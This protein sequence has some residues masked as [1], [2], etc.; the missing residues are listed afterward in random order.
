[1]KALFC[2]D[3]PIQRNEVGQHYSPVINNIVFNRYLG[4]A[5][6]LKVAI[7]VSDFNNP[8]DARKS[9]LIDE[10]NVEII[11]IP[12]LSSANGIIFSKAK[13]THILA[14]Q[15]RSVDFSIIRLPSFIGQAAVNIARKLHKP[16]LVEI[17]G[18]PWDSLWNYGLKGKFVAPWLTLSMKR[19]VKDA[20]YAIYV[21]NSFLQSRYPTNGVSINCSDVEINA[22]DDWV[23]QSRIDK[24]RKN[25]AK[26]ILG[27][28]AAVNVPY[29]GQQYVI[30]ALGRMK[31][32][33]DTKYVY[34]MVGDGD[35]SRLEQVIRENDVM[36]Q[37]EFLGVKTH[38]KVFEWLDSI[39]I[40]VQPSRQE[41]LPRALIEA[42]SRGLPAVGAATGGI[43][44]LIA[45]ECIFSN[46][47]NN[48]GEIC[49][50]LRAYTPERMEQEARRNY[51]NSKI[52]L[53][54]HI[55]RRRKQLLDAIISEVK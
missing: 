29:K 33:G 31:K 18:C 42:M 40:Y 38:E 2:Y 14:E 9:K 3:G 15:M 32:E 39:D 19:Q 55:K 16:Y 7:R 47:A 11:P 50:L 53:I 49:K 8:R 28:T 24:I 34:Q 44:E 48:I 25:S 37:V 12:N 43:P 52:Y 54:D 17:V 1:M 45:S 10:T 36:D 35:R 4:H 5:D 30:E 21:T 22:I 6:F 46:T 23:F 41:G 20:P 51:E 27:T 26:L 13:A